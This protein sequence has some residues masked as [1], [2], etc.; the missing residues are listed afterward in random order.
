M[1]ST[2][3]LLYVIK[4]YKHSDIKYTDIIILYCIV[5]VIVQYSIFVIC[6]KNI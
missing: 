5:V 2:V 3:F 1:Y 6:D 4:I